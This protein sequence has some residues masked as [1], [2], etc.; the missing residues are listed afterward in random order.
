M[1][2]GDCS[3]DVGYWGLTLYLTQW[4]DRHILID[5]ITIPIALGVYVGLEG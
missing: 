1:E 5:F 3:L 4:G 2:A